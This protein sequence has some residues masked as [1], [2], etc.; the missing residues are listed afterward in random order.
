LGSLR[1]IA[2]RNK[3]KATGNMALANSNPHLEPNKVAQAWSKNVDNLS[4]E[5]KD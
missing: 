1:A 4:R 3:G 2:D 5:T